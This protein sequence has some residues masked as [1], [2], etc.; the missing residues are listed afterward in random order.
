M[1]FILGCWDTWIPPTCVCGLCWPD[2]L[3]LITLIC[4]WSSHTHSQEYKFSEI[5][6]LVQTRNCATT[7]NGGKCHLKWLGYTKG[8]MTGSPSAWSSYWE[9]DLVIASMR[10]HV[11][12]IMYV[13]KRQTQIKR[14]HHYIIQDQWT[15]VTTTLMWSSD[16]SSPAQYSYSCRR[17]SLLCC[18]SMIVELL[19]LT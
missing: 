6:H 2:R 5:G 12:S 1:S 17:G 19:S 8:Y 14:P 11:N 10:A 13:Y 16:W 9:R 4:V 18:Y 15:T 7:N 3:H